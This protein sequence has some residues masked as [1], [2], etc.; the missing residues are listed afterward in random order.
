LTIQRRRP[1]PS[2]EGS[3]PEI[4]QFKPT[5][6][7]APRSST[8][9]G[10]LITEIGRWVHTSGPEFRAAVGD[11]KVDRD[12]PMDAVTNLGFIAVTIRN[13]TMEIVLHVKEAQVQAIN[14]LVPMLA[15][16]SVSFFRIVYFS[17]NWY[18]ETATSGREAAKRIVVLCADAQIIRCK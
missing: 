10:F 9:T 13:A 16:S 4:A 7:G 18:E 8:D 1:D 6:I 15:S 12:A 2:L 3:A 11:L 17:E 14:A 5:S